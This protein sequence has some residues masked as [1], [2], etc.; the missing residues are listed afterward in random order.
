M[1]KV[2]DKIS[3]ACLEIQDML[4]KQ[5]GEVRIGR[6]KKLE[7]SLKGSRHDTTADGRK[8]RN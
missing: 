4:V 8:G 3:G 7:G 2:G 1:C 5:I 6:K